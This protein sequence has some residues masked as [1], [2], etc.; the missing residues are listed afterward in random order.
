MM[1]KHIKYIVYAILW[2][3]QLGDAPNCEKRSSFEV[4]LKFRVGIW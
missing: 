3:K 1:N 2:S 4:K